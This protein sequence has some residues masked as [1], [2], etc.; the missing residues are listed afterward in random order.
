MENERK[1]AVIVLGMH[2]SGTSAVAG[3]AVRL[4]IAPPRTPLPAA[5]DNPGGFYESLSVVQLNHQMLRAAGC[6]WNLCLTFEPEQRDQ[7]L[8]PEDR[9]IIAETLRQEFPGN[10]GFVLKDPRLCMTLPAWLP[11]LHAIEADASGLLVVRHPEEVIRS[12]ARRN[13]LPAA[14]TAAQWL[15]HML[16]AERLSRGLP[17]AVLFYDDLMRDWRGCMTE[18]GRTAHIAW[19]KPIDGTRTDRTGREIDEFIDRSSRHYVAAQSTA[20]VGPP[21]VGDMVDATWTALRR[22]SDNPGTPS[23]RACLDRVRERFAI[24]RRQACPPGFEVVMPEA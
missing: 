12:L 1:F 16:E 17:R 4:G 11:A 6:A 9:Q 10:S 5:D 7:M 3:T 14:E 23:A 8:H 22:L 24:W 21:P 13:Q 15:H 19:P 2:R 18:A 20:V